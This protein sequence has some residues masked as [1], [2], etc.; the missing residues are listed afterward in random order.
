MS[1]KTKEYIAS[2][3]GNYYLASSLYNSISTAIKNKNTFLEQKTTA[4]EIFEK[5]LNNSIRDI[6]KHPR[7]KLFQ[8]LIEFGSLNPDETDLSK[9]PPETYLS[10]EECVSAVNFIYS[11]IINRFKGDLAELL[12]I[13]AVIQLKE[14][15]ENKGQIP[16]NL[17]ICLGDYIKEYQKTGSL[18]KG[19]D[20]LIVELNTSSKIAKI[21]AV[22]EV[23]SM[24]MPQTKMIKQIDKHIYR[25]K[26]GLQLGEQNYPA[27]NVKFDK[28]DIIKI[29]IIPSY[30]RVNRGFT[31]QGNKM[32]L[33]KPDRPENETSIIEIEKNLLKITLDWSQ[34]ALEQAAYEM[35]FN[36]MAE[37]GRIVYESKPLPKGWKRMSP[38]EAGYN[39]IKEK[40]YYIMLPY[41]YRDVKL[42]KKQIIIKRKMVKLYNV[43]SFGY[44]MGIDS[45]EMLWP[46]DIK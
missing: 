22:I 2:I 28:S 41:H 43:Y 9:Y 18:A 3:I 34:D 6:E 5:T 15:L 16:S 14:L 13:K 42:S 37:V 10:D 26:K 36:Y 19:A 35:T 21:K 11:H 4:R 17:S 27:E 8:R 39:S 29:M 1:Q 33:P 31:W 46:E 23:K 24:Y 32:V 40:L 38:E 44:Q 20:G 12:S 25:L 7:G 30:W 45:K